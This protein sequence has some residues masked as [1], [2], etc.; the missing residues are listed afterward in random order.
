[1]AA[2]GTLG[3]LYF[4]PTEVVAASNSPSVGSRDKGPSPAGEDKREPRDVCS[5]E[6]AEVMR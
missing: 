4:H 1:M 5:F 6:L 3:A 2:L